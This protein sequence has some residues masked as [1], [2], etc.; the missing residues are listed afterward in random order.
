M[1]AVFVHR[2]GHVATIPLVTQ[3]T[4]TSAWYTTECLPRVLASVAERR[5]RTR[6]RGLL[7]HHDNAAAHRA[8]ATQDFLNGER[9]QQ[10]DHPPY[11][12]DLAPCD[13]FVFLFVKSKLCGMRFNTSDLTVKAFLE[14]SEAI[15]QLEWASMFQKWFHRMQKC[16]D[17]AGEYFEKM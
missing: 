6:H 9:I 5:P 16:I 13:V 17:T 14:H 10:L 1:I 7:L 12:P 15:P 4:V 3:S 8:A 11:S 2:V